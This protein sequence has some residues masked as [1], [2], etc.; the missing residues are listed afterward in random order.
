MTDMTHWRGELTVLAD[1]CVLR[2]VYLDFLEVRVYSSN[3][4][5]V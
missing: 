1:M 2:V 4:R 3:W 5:N